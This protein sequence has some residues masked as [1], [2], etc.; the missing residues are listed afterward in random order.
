MPTKRTIRTP[1]HNCRKNSAKEMIGHI[2]NPCE[3]QLEDFLLTQN[4]RPVLLLIYKFINK[5][6]II[7]MIPPVL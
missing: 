6:E 3:Q 2:T 4:I 1:F 5:K 7:F